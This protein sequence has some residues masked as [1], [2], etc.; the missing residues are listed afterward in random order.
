MR[1]LSFLLGLILSSY[2]LSEYKQLE[3]PEAFEYA[4]THFPLR[5]KLKKKENLLYVEIPENFLEILPLL[6]VEGIEPPPYFGKDLVGLHI[7]VIAPSEMNQLSLSEMAEL[8]QD[9]SFDL[10]GIAYAKPE[11]LQDIEKVYFLELEAKSLENLRIHYG[12]PAKIQD[13][14]FHIT[15]G[16]EKKP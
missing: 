8:G 15:I 7:T 16:V 10:K 2:L 4:K 14:E 9:F 5:G 6:P 3:A 13:H 12:L 1:K 11:N